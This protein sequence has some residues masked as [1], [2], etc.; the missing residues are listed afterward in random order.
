MGKVGLEVLEREREKG[1]REDEEREKR[2]EREEDRGR[3]VEG[4]WSRTTW[5]TGTESSKGF[6][7]WGVK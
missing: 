5:P 7:T 1:G 6:P 4:R 3:E 2:E